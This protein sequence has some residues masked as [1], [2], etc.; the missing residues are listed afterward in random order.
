MLI[1]LIGVGVVGSTL[2]KWFQE[3]TDHELRLYD[4]EKGHLDFLNG[5]EAI[6]VSVPVPHNESGQDQS[7]LKKCVSKAQEYTD[8]VF[9]R[10]TVLPNT[11]DSLGTIA[12]PE[13]LTERMAY[14]DMCK[15]PVLCGEVDKEFIERKAGRVFRPDREFEEG[16]ASPAEKLTRID[17]QFLPSLH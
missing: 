1:G 5:C 8:K 2:A 12:M 6:F 16:L 9:I 10:S 14:E 11:N 13:F 15:Y 17:C 4:P 7:I 3:H